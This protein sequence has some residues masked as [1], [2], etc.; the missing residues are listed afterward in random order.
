MTLPSA[1][2]RIELHLA[3]SKEFPVGSARHGYRLVA[4]L[5]E[6]GRI[7]LALWKTH[8]E[9]CRVHRFWQG[10]PDETGYLVHKAGGSE[11]ARWVFDYDKTR[12]DDD[13][14]GYRL[15]AHVFAVGEYVT[16]RGEDNDYTFKVVSVEPVR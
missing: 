5:D 1:F 4:P 3:R 12:V 11:R 6:D 14:S 9:R 10:E 7:D 16:I 15:G 2:K 8:R 13:E